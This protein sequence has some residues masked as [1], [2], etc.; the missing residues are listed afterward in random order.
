[1]TK[2]AAPRQ[3]DYQDLMVTD[4]SPSLRQASPQEKP[5]DLLWENCKVKRD[6]IDQL[7]K[8]PSFQTLS[9]MSYVI[10]VVK[11]KV[12]L[13]SSGQVLFLLCCEG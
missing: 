8:F 9:D 10:K 4:K 12:G 3:E 2:A 13:Y 11:D 6:L 7:M 1:M 5:R